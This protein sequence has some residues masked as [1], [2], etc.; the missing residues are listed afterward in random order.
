VSRLVPHSA[1]VAFGYL[2]TAFALWFG[3]YTGLAHSWLTPF[4]TFINSLTDYELTAD[5]RRKTIVCPTVTF[6]IH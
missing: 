6:V 2:V 4:A 5:R 3:A 1:G